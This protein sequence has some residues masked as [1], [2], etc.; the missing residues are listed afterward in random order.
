MS[1]QIRCRIVLTALKDRA[2]LIK[3]DEFFKCVEQSDLAQR[4]SQT[5]ES[6]YHPR[7]FS[8]N[9]HGDLCFDLPAFYLKHGYAYFINGRHRTLV[10][11]KHMAVMPMALTSHDDESK[12]TLAN[13]VDREIS[14]GSYVSLP[15]FNFD[16]SWSD[17]Y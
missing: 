1:K 12:S 7:W 13:I 16:P 9:Q 15:H 5:I 8:Q 17:T 6:A 3:R 10:L 14:E 11:A 2:F 4:E